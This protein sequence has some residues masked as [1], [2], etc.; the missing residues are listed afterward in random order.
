VSV[1]TSSQQLPSFALKNAVMCSVKDVRLAGSMKS[2]EAEP[3]RL[4]RG[5]GVAE[6]LLARERLSRV[7][8]VPKLAALAFALIATLTACGE[9]RDK[10]T[11][12]VPDGRHVLTEAKPGDVVKCA[13]GGGATVPAPGQGVGGAA[14]EGLSSF[15]VGT[16]DD[17]TVVVRCG[18]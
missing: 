16:R 2:R 18:S 9:S 8:K 10:R 3:E 15:S 4:R 11:F 7:Q 12:I 14:S 17:G 6:H 5:G 1:T 13:S